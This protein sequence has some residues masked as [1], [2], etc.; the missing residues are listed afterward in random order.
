MSSWGITKDSGMLFREVKE[1]ERRME[2]NTNSNIHGVCKEGIHA[3][4]TPVGAT[5]GTEQPAHQPAP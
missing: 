3:S 2:I 1:K 4:D 5:S